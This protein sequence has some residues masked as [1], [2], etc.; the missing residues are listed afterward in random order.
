VKIGT[1]LPDLARKH[2]K[3]CLRENADMFAWHATE[4][5]GLD[6]NVACH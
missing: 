1:W 4:M 5:L 3:A 2:L 6:P